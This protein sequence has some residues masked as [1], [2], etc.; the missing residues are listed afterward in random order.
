MKVIAGM[1]DRIPLRDIGRYAQHVEALG[2]DIL[3]VPE[4]IHDSMAVALLAL[5]HTTTL[6][7]QTSLTLAFPRSLTLAR[8]AAPLIQPNTSSIRLR[9]R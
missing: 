4:T 5:E 8:P 3:H 2:Y 6:R 1:S 7:V 9:Q